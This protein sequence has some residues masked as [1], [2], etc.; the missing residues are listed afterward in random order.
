MALKVKSFR[1]NNRITLEKRLNEWFA[2]DTENDIVILKIKF[3][4]AGA[5]FFYVFVIYDDVSEAI[6]ETDTE[7]VKQT[8]KELMKDKLQGL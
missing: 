4:V 1:T 2:Q 5:N 3:L 8:I 7:A 6:K